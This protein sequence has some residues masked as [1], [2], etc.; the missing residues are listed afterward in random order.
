M[1][2]DVI[3]V[4]YC[5]IV[6]Q[7]A[8]EEY[9]EESGSRDDRRQ[10]A[11]KTEFAGATLELHADHRYELKTA[12]PYGSYGTWAV[13]RRKLELTQADDC[14]SGFESFEGAGLSGDELVMEFK[15]IPDA[16]DGLDILALRFGREA[17]VVRVAPEGFVARIRDAQDEDELY[18]LLDEELGGPD[19]AARAREVWDAWKAGELAADR[20]ADRYELELAVFR[21]G[22]VIE[23]GAFTHEHAKHALATIDPVEDN[24]FAYTIENGLLRLPE[25]DAADAELGKLM[26]PAWVERFAVNR[27]TG[28]GHPPEFFRRKLMPQPAID[29]ATRRL[30]NKVDDYSRFDEIAELFP[31]AHPDLPSIALRYRGYE[32]LVQPLALLE[33]RDLLHRTYDVAAAMLDEPGI[34]G[35]RAHSAAQWAL[36]LA[37]R[38]GKPVPDG[39]IRYLDGKPQGGMGDLQKGEKALFAAAIAGFDNALQDKVKKRYHL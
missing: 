8:S 34:K 12:E 10:K 37:G 2:N 1:S 18:M 19:A 39:A 32:L 31:G 4:W 38:L 5:Q 14:I 11:S 20:T 17:P 29:D 22:N 6:E 9:E 24:D 26:T 23:G 25:D 15:L 13:K 7:Y 35:M 16:H 3:G 33:Q 28:G 27:I 30:L 36:F 21:D